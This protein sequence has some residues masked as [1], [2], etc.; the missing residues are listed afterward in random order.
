MGRSLHVLTGRAQEQ[1]PHSPNLSL[2][3]EDVP[4]RPPA[5][6]LQVLLTDKV[7]AAFSLTPTK[8]VTSPWSR[9]RVCTRPIAAVSF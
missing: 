7:A 1:A 6:G 8:A 9:R 2:P 4:S 3:G 5:A